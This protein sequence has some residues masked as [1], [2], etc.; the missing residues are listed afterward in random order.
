MQGEVLLLEKK[1]KKVTS[2]KVSAS[3]A[4]N[5]SL[6]YIRRELKLTLSFTVSKQ[7]DFFFFV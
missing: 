2:T 7:G 6:I 3:H 4:V 1:T 5:P